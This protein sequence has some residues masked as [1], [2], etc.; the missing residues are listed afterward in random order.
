MQLG[1]A[2]AL[3]VQQTL[4]LHQEFEARLAEAATGGGG[5]SSV[6]QALQAVFARASTL[7]KGS[8]ALAPLAALVKALREG[9]DQ[10][11]DA[12]EEALRAAQKQQ[13]VALT[14]GRVSW[15]KANIK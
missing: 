11:G 1:Q 3:H 12:M 13:M 2:Q 6:R 4:S 7:S 15:L 9:D 14:S 5:G 10:C 8:D